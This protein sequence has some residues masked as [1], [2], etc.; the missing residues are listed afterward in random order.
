[1]NAITLADPGA[2]IPESELI[3]NADGSVYHLAMRPDQLGDVVLLVGDPGRVEQVSRHFSSI[4]HRTQHREFI[5]HTGVLDGTHITVLSTGIGPDNIDIVMNELDA[6]ANIDLQRRI[7]KKDHRELRIIRLGTC[8]A[9]QEDL[10]CG[11]LI[12]SSFAVGLDGLLHYYAF[13]NTDQETRLLNTLIEQLEWP[14]NLP[15]PYVAQ[16][17]RKLVE[18]LS[19]GNTEGITF[20]AG[21]F[22]GP[23]G[24]RLRLVPSIDEFNQQLA[25]FEYQGLRAANFEM[26]TS[27]I[28]GLGG[29]LGHRAC[30]VCTVVANRARREFSRDV[31][32]DVD[33]MIEQ[34][35]DRITV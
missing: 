3:L 27:A 22:Y 16:G 23:Q 26:E 11:S 15:L 29:M 14:G 24:R 34:V 35:F 5:A 12:V 13:E 9:L 2:E 31:K 7:A 17:D 21:G 32:T 30:T 33:R 19:N 18:L 4:E 28:Y 1:M 8:G 6:L 25:S 20:T 10:P